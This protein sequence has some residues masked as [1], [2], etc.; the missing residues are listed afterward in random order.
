MN[1][2][3]DASNS[4]IRMP[5]MAAMTPSSTITSHASSFNQDHNVANETATLLNIHGSTNTLTNAG[6]SSF[7]TSVV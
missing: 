2:G 7:A 1:G 6:N 3:I 4:Q 5:T